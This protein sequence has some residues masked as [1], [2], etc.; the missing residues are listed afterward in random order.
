MGFH[1]TAFSLLAFSLLALSVSGA[2]PPEPEGGPTG[3]RLMMGWADFWAQKDLDQ[4]EVFYAADAIYEDVPAGTS[5]VG[6]DNIKQS[7]GEDIAYAPDVM[8]EV[9]SSFVSGD[10]G[11][12]EWVWSGTQTGDIPG[13]L[14]ATGK[15]FSVRGVS[16]FTFA[17]GKI[18]KQSDYYDGGG[19]LYQLGVEL[20]F[21]E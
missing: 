19:F 11:V 10:R 15:A 14:P 1:R 7:L 17:D 8:V 4:L 2:G 20:K 9:V 21:P 3:E 18:K 5:Y 13:L 16:T 12:M 6:I